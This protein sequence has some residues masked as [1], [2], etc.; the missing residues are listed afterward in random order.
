MDKDKTIKE[1][2]FDIETLLSI[3]KEQLVSLQKKAD[4]RKLQK[5]RA[6]LVDKP[7]D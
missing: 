1:V 7:G 2:S 6:E 3:Q 4:E 5:L